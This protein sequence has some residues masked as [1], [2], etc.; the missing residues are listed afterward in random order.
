MRKSQKLIERSNLDREDSR[1]E[2]DSPVQ[3]QPQTQ[4]NREKFVK[5][6]KED[7]YVSQAKQNTEKCVVKKKDTVPKYVDIP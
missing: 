7:E 4:L 2:I 1:R 3:V 6:Q 5:K